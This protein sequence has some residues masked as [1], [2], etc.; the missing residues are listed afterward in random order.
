MPFFLIPHWVCLYSL[1]VANGSGECVVDSSQG[2]PECR[3]P[4]PKQCNRSAER[5]RQGILPSAAEVV[6]VES[7][8]MR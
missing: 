3:G 6:V 8:C 7:P 4:M 2:S 5:R 1:R